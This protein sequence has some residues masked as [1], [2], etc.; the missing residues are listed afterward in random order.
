MKAEGRASERASDETIRQTD[1]QV[2]R[3]WLLFAP[4]QCLSA[5]MEVKLASLGLTNNNNLNERE[6]LFIFS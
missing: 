4:F 6:S 5:N 1:G 3:A 2:E